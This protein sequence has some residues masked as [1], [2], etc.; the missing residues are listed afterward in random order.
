MAH[1][2]S[3]MR[4]SR[5]WSR[6]RRRRPRR[7]A[8]VPPSKVLRSSESI[9]EQHHEHVGPSVRRAGQAVVQAVDHAVA[10][11]WMAINTPPA[12]LEGVQKVHSAGKCLLER[13]RV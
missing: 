5:R 7:V 2:P 12:K 10:Y 4:P 9:P 1:V 13:P 11:S 8:D 6:R 3:S